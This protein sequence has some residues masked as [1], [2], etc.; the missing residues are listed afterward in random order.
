MLIQKKFCWNQTSQRWPRH[1]S[2]CN[3]RWNKRMKAQK[4]LL[5]E[6]L[7]R[8]PCSYSRSAGVMRSIFYWSGGIGISR[9]VLLTNISI[10]RLVRNFGQGA[11]PCHSGWRTGVISAWPHC[12]VVLWWVGVLATPRLRGAWDELQE[13]MALDGNLSKPLIYDFIVICSRENSDT[14]SRSSICLRVNSPRRSILHSCMHKKLIEIAPIQRHLWRTCQLPDSK[15]N[16]EM[17]R[18]MSS[19]RCI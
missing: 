10:E 9:I 14:Y 11:K 13:P 3:S 12:C 18:D 19:N 6:R 5:W 8:L 15:S 4:Y 2:V 17:Q 16:V 7:A 1:N